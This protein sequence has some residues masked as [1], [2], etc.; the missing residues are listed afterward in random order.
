LLKSVNFTGES[1][2]NN[3][4]TDV[5]L[6]SIL[7]PLSLRLSPAMRALCVML[8][9]TAA[10]GQTEQALLVTGLPKSD[11]FSLYYSLLKPN[12]RSFLL[13]IFGL[14]ERGL[15][16]A[17]RVILKTKLNGNR[18]ALSINKKYLNSTSI[19]FYLNGE[20]ISRPFELCALAEKI[21][22]LSRKSFRD[23]SGLVVVDE[24]NHK[25]KAS[26][27]STLLSYD[28]CNL[29]ALAIAD[30]D[31]HIQKLNRFCPSLSVGLVAQLESTLLR[32]VATRSAE[33]LVE[34]LGRSKSDLVHHAHS[35]YYVKERE[36][37]SLR[38]D[39][40]EDDRHTL[41]LTVVCKDSPSYSLA[42]YSLDGN[43]RF[44]KIKVIG[45]RS[46]QKAARRLVECIAIYWASAYRYLRFNM[47]SVIQR[48]NP[49][50]VDHMYS[51]IRR[52]LDESG[53]SD[54]VATEF[55]LYAH[56]DGRA[57]YLL[58]SQRYRR[59]QS[60]LHASTSSHWV[61][62]KTLLSQKVETE[63]WYGT[64]VLLSP[65]TMSYTEAVVPRRAWTGTPDSWKRPVPGF[66]TSEVAIYGTGRST[67][68][69][70]SIDCEGNRIAIC[71]IFTSEV[72]EALSGKFI[73]LP[74]DYRRTLK[75]AAEELVSLPRGVAPPRLHVPL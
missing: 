16:L 22:S 11:L 69:P 68:E 47:A 14:S 38:V 57:R 6:H 2:H 73:G 65:D 8:A 19:H 13:N 66:G 31:N 60:V 41:L 61:N 35:V 30:V 52:Y 71:A 67:A 70:L 45:C 49:P 1:P 17:R 36:S 46:I 42:E 12:R 40:E 43:Y 27:E 18:I 15:P 32:I 33:L 23:R 54:V 5:T 48:F 59:V 7:T 58:D 29:A 53:L 24:D 26:F 20:K 64:S 28:A 3:S 37:W 62:S 9:R 25:H 50:I 4:A 10:E 34:Q 44:S 74:A 21:N 72:F 39:E 56:I 51:T 75:E 55:S 63:A